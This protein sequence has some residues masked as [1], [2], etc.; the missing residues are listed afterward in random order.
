MSAD[1]EEF[2]QEM[3]QFLEDFREKDDFI[4]RNQFN[5]EFLG[6]LGVFARRASKSDEG[7]K[8]RFLK[9]VEFAMSFLKQHGKINASKERS[10]FRLISLAF[11]DLDFDYGAIPLHGVKDDCSAFKGDSLEVQ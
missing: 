8:R 3:E 1:V 7:A 6:H 4:R 2:L 9:L 10:A 5:D 11:P